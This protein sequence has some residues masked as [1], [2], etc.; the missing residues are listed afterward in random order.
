ML[1]WESTQTI[2][3]LDVTL[4]FTQG[5]IHIPERRLAKLQGSRAT[6]LY[7]SD[8]LVRVLA[9]LTSQIIAM[10]CAVRNLTRLLIEAVN[11]WDHPILISSTFRYKLQFWL[12][13]IV[14]MYSAGQCHQAKCSCSSLF[15]C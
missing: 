3:T 6:C 8:V 9:F 13:N 11:H 1:V 2:T 4:N 15:R 12:H 7:R 14:S 5:S 10:S